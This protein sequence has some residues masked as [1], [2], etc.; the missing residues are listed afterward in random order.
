MK[1][2]NIRQLEILTFR[3]TTYTAVPGNSQFDILSAVLLNDEQY[4]QIL[5][6]QVLSVGLS[7]IPAFL[8]HH[9]SRVNEPVLWLNNLEKLIKL[10]A[11]HFSD[12]Q[13]RHRHTKLITQI[14]LLRHKLTDKHRLP[15]NPRLN[16]YSSKRHYN[17]EEVKTALSTY[18]VHEDK[19]AYLTNQIYDYRQDT[20]DFVNPNQPSFD[21]LCELEIER[22]TKTREFNELR[23]QRQGRGVRKMPFKGRIKVLCDLFFKGMNHRTPEGETLLPWSITEAAQFICDNFHDESGQNLSFDTV[24]TY[25]SASRPESR[26]KADQEIKL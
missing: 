15:K 12:N 17:F 13:R 3:E 6:N 8:E 18:E 19:I 14:D 1:K 2:K 20:P 24:R 22:L 21:K 10:N 5:F 9:C 16:A 25:L 11:H 23:R 26:P 4:C 7:E